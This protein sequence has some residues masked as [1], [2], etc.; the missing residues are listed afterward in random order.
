MKTLLVIVFALLAGC[1][2]AEGLPMSDGGDGVDGGP[3]QELT[4]ACGGIGAPC[5]P[6]AIQCPRST[7]HICHSGTCQ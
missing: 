5:C 7:K 6:A 1:G 4:I 3:S 2:G